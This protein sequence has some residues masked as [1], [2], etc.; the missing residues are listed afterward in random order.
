MLAGPLIMAPSSTTVP[1]PTNTRSPIH[2]VPSHLLCKAGRRLPFRYSFSL[3]SPS[4]A[5]SQPSN[6]AAW[7]VWE[8]SNRSAGLNMA[9]SLRKS[10]LRGKRNGRRIKSQMQG[11]AHEVDHRMHNSAPRP[12]LRGSWEASLGLLTVHWDHELP[13]SET[14]PPRCCRHLAGSAFLRLVC[15]QDAGSTLRFMASRHDID[16]M[17]WPVNPPLTP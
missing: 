5:Y 13:T 15:R 10:G 1:S 3:R 12:L 6:S 2:A 11:A 4:Q 14:A 7:V 8:R 9:R 17:R 16:A